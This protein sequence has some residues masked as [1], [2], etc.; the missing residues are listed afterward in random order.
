MAWAK[1]LSLAAIL[2]NYCDYQN[3]V[4]M[5]IKASGVLPESKYFEKIDQHILTC[6]A[7]KFTPAR[8]AKSVLR[9][10]ENLKKAYDS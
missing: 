8:A 3:E 5:R 4:V 9:L 1:K 7:E 2:A 6:Y 10:L